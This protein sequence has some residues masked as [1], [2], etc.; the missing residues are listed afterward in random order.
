VKLFV[1]GIGSVESGRE[2]A[3]ALDFPSLNLLVDESD[4]TE[5]YRLAGT[6][7]SQRTSDNKQI[8]EGIESMWSDKTNDSLNERRKEDL[9]KIVGKPFSPGIYKPL[10]PKGKS[11]FDTRVIEKTLVQGGSFVFQG[12]N[13][14]VEHMDPA[15]GAHL[16]LTDLMKSALGAVPQPQ[17]Q[18]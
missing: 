6:R 2:F 3:Q 14:L 11:F 12:D 17:L 5:A 13:C 18:R 7:N 16:P 15:S 8:F 10:M 4:E 9:N 1:V